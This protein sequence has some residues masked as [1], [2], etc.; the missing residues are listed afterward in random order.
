MVALGLVALVV[1][2]APISDFRRLCLLSGGALCG[3]AW[4]MTCLTKASGHAALIQATTVALTLPYCFAALSAL[5]A[6]HLPSTPAPFRL[7]RA[8]T[9]LLPVV[10]GLLWAWFPVAGARGVT[11]PVV[12]GALLALALLAAAARLAVALTQSRAEAIAHGFFP[13][14]VGI[15]ALAETVTQVAWLAPVLVIGLWWA[16][17]VAHLAP[18]LP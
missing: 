6:T 14:S 15:H 9:R 11:G 7:A 10:V 18:P 8:A 17:S 13:G 3:L 4:V 2:F 12:A 16:S 1:T 5:E